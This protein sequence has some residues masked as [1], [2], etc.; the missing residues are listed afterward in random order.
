MNAAETARGILTSIEPPKGR[1]GLTVPQEVALAQAY[2]TLALAE[3]QEAANA[4]AALQLG[5][6]G[7]EH[8]DTT[9]A[10]TKTARRI[11]WRNRLRSRIREGL[12][13]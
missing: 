11:G 9:S 7:L 3:A 10:D 13:L 1:A 2:A 8:D 5:V 4:I 6:P 12:G